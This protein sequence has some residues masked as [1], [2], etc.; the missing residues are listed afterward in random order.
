MQ[1]AQVVG[2]KKDHLGIAKFDHQDDWDFTVVAAH[3]SEMAGTAP[4]NTAKKWEWY[5]RHEGV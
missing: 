5:E 3:L 1:N 2:L 4:L